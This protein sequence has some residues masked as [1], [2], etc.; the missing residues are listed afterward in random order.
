MGSVCLN[1]DLAAPSSRSS[2]SSRT[3]YRTNKYNKY[4]VDPGYTRQID[5][6]TCVCTSN[7]THTQRQ[8][9]HNTLQSIIR[10]HKHVC[11]INMFVFRFS[12]PPASNIVQLV[13]EVWSINY[14]GVHCH[15]NG[16][17][18]LHGSS[19]QSQVPACHMHYT[20]DQD[21]KRK[22]NPQVYVA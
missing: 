5:R 21:E 19:V 17:M 13:N 16:R 12:S 9:V 4:L 15:C 2:I 3:I 1:R 10:L 8:H 7:T 20:S 14:K 22:T 11:F 18:W 6:C